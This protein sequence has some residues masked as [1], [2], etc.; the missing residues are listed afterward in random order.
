M[1]ESV[2]DFDTFMNQMEE[3]SAQQVSEAMGRLKEL[4]GNEIKE[5]ENEENEENEEHERNEG[6]KEEARDSEDLADYK[7]E[8]AQI[9]KK[10][11]E[12]LDVDHKNI[13]YEPIHKA[14]YVEV[15]DIKKLKKE[16]VKEI[17]RIELEGC[18]VKGKNCPKPIRTWSECGINPI[19]MDVIKALKYEK[20]SPVQRQAIPV[21]MSGYDAI[22][23]AKTGSGKT[24]A[25]T[26]P[27]IKHVMA[28][29]PLSKGEGPIGIVFAPIRELA[30]QINTEI[31]KFG[32]YLN[33]RSV[34]VF[35]GT[36]I[37]NQI[38]ALKRGTEIVVCTPGRMIDILVTNNGRITNLRRVTF[39]VLDE[40]DRMFDMGFGPQ[41]KRIIEGI[42][43]DKQIVMFSATFPISV[44][45][46]AREFLKKP[47]EIICGGRS[48]VS[49]TIEQIV[50][51]IE[52]KKKIERLISIVLEQN[53]KG[54][55]IIIFTETQKN[56][57]ELYQNLMERN[58]NC[59]LLHGGIDQIDR[60]NTIQE[61]KSGIGRTILITTSLCARGLDVKG[62]EL[63]I[64]YD[65]PNHLED[66][67]HRVG[68]TG[69]AGKRGKAITFITKE[70]ERYSE[71][72][73]KALTLSG[74]SISKELND[75]YE[76][77]KTKKLFLETKEGKKGYGGNGF[78][79]DI[80]EEITTMENKIGGYME[81]DI[82]GG[83]KLKERFEEKKMK[84]EIKESNIPKE[85]QEMVQK[86]LQMI[87][88]I[89]KRMT[90]ITNNG[91]QCKI[92]INDFS[93][94]A[95]QVL[96]SK[97][98]LISVM[99]NCNV[100]ITTR[101]SYIGE[102]KT[103]LPG[104]SKLYL[105]IEGKNEEDITKAKKEIKN[106]LDEITLKYKDKVLHEKVISNIL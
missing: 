60:Q 94:Q 70:E 56:C 63:V 85:K 84:E 47:I 25:Y 28:Q 81:E 72:I 95:R 14:L 53:N 49:N 61:F 77:W 91:V 2:D 99:E 33:I 57:D 89:N 8:L 69:R 74:G 97:E 78:K 83:I 101:G 9:K 17:R 35:G 50:E 45:Q 62:L 40:A 37:S 31:N 13:Q 38:G 1:D 18:I 36:G 65:C 82:G 92:E 43:P 27:L 79:F 98:K 86:A 12:L 34:A 58:I 100:N 76:E 55:R 102:G 87:E 71:D 19:T 80:K 11:L 59:L 3:E 44:E 22:V 23:C 51:V 105:L 15:P 21:I 106:I 90:K 52:T 48:Q 68:R 4:K 39:V 96:T 16:E 93:I 41:I 54:G 66:Y 75:M 24:L 26:I 73:V 20:P 42:R 46:H 5:I 7:D 32:K 103:P 88:R 67:V 30:E 10:K 64:N 104:Q 6:K 29:R